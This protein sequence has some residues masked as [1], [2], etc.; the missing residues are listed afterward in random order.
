VLLG[1]NYIQE[2]KETLPF[3]FLTV[4]LL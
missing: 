3:F 4:E 1:V 2:H